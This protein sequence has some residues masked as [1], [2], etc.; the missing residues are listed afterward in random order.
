MK[1]QCPWCEKKT[2]SFYQKQTLGP[3]RSIKCGSCTRRVSVPWDR[4]QL[5]A[6]P[7]IILGTLGLVLGK[8]LYG[9][10]SAILLGGWIG[11]TLGMCI[12]APLYHLWV[13]LVK[14]TR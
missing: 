11:L 9:S 2:F 1:Y 4:A 10:V 12:T 14:P 5:A 13:P 7:V 8:Q 3:S 6:L